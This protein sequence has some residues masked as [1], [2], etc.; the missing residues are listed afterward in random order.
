MHIHY[1][2]IVSA[3]TH[4]HSRTRSVQ[5]MITSPPLPSPVMFYIHVPTVSKSVTKSVFR[6]QVASNFGGN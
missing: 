6:G 3:S 4:I 1:Y 5:E 2:T